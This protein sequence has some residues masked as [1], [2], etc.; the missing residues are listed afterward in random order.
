MDSLPPQVL[1][2]VDVI[3]A[4]F[5]GGVFSL[6]SLIISKNQKTSEFGQQLA[7]VSGKYA[8]EADVVGRHGFE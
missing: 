7:A 8:Q 4:V 2:S 3:L 6:I 5:I 1:I